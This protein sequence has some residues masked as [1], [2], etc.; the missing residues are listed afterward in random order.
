MTTRLALYNGALLLCKERSLASLSESAEPRRLLDEVWNDG[1]VRY[2]LE[3]GQWRF[4]MRT[5]KLTY[6]TA[7]EPAF[8]YR[9]AF[10]KPSDWVATS[11]VCADEY[12]TEP[13]LR[14]SDEDQFIFSD[15]DDI[16]A[17][18]VSDDG[19]FGTDYG[20][21]PQ[22]FAEYVKTYFA[23]RICYKLGGKD[24]ITLLHG[25]A[26]DG[27]DGL[28]ARNLLIAKNRDAM[29]DPTRFA[30]QGGWTRSR[31]RYARGGRFEDGGSSSNLIG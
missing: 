13:L 22:S 10:A 11:A 17:K 6:D 24:I 3:Q 5:S 23:S 28:L 31:G 19:A 18:Y 9:R 21:W 20:K 26:I 4:A 12:F 30:A 27:R 15:I 14:Y 29:A 25:R 8:G 1:G 16:Y 7:I 2:C